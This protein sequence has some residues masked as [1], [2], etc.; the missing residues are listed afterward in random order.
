MKKIW[1]MSIVACILSLLAFGCNKAETEDIITEIAKKNSK[2]PTN[3]GAN[4]EGYGTII[5]GE[6]NG[7]GNG[8]G[9]EPPAADSIRLVFAGD[10]ILSGKVKDVVI[11]NGN[12]NYQYLFQYAGDYL[13]NADLAFINL[14]SIITSEGT[15]ENNSA[16]RADPAAVNGLTYAGID[17]VSVAN[18]HAFDYGRTGFDSSLQN[19]KNAGISCIG[20]GTF[21]E[22][23]TA[24][25]I[26]VKGTRVAF[27]A[28]TNLGNEYS[29]RAQQNDPSQG[30]SAR[31]GVAWYYM[32]YVGPAI[33]S[34]KKQADIVIVSLHM[35]K[36]GEKLPNLSQDKRAHY[37]VD[38]GASLVIGHH[39][40]VI[41]PVMVYIKGHIAYSLGNFI[42][43][44]EGFDAKKGIILEVVV[45]NKQIA[46]INR[47]YV[48]INS[49]YQPV[50]Q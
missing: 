7:N 38:Q 37:C 45:S 1:L 16:L 50:V 5:P 6:E 13:R 49:N 31:T 43:D 11:S 40:Q 14:E 44:Q 41:Q 26:D 22:S 47:K 33:I 29:V 28:F 17:V 48:Y 36:A 2:A 12:G 35:G 27:L 18:D 42:T 15:S 30:L 3:N 9:T 4:N 8:T 24:K 10:T 25:I 23:Y 19:M 39:P 32:K 34:A 21:E 46:K 20:G